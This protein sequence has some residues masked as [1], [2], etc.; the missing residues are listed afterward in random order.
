MMV[1]VKMVMSMVKERMVMI[2][3]VSD[4]EKEAN[5]KRNRIVPP[6]NPFLGLFVEP[7]PVENRLNGENGHDG[8]FM[9]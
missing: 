9:V 2:T 5:R 6:S 7:R 4:N 3:L 8:K 1:M